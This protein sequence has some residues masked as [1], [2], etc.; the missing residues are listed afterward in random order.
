MMNRKIL[1]DSNLINASPSP[2]KTVERKEKELLAE[3]VLALSQE[4]MAIKEENLILRSKLNEY[5]NLCNITAHDLEEKFNVLI[6]GKNG[7]K[8]EIL[9][10]KDLSAK[11][12]ENESGIKESNQIRQNSGT[13][14]EKK[15]IEVFDSMQKIGD[16]FK[17]EIERYSEKLRQ[18]EKDYDELYMKYIVEYGNI[19]N[20]LQKNVNI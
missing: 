2:I 6:E 11:K 3:K 18:K 19:C 20:F 4:N 7:L 15:V 5:E 9:R 1:G 12:N 13:F 14:N 8:E 10:F 17:E 16:F